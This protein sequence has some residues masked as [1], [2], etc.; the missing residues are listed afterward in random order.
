[1]AAWRQADGSTQPLSDAELAIEGLVR[2][3]VEFAGAAASGVEASRVLRWQAPLQSAE[4]PGVD[5]ARL[6]R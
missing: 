1:V 5:P 4:A 6:S 3:R 2:S